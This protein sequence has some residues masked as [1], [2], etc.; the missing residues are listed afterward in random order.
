MNGSKLGNFDFYYDR[1]ALEQIVL[2]K[3]NT[4]NNLLFFDVWTQLRREIF[5][6]TAVRTH[7]GAGRLSH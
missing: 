7:L 3:L 5:S 4:H 1:S 2:G 6:R